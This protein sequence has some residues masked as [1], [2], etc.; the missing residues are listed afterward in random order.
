MNRGDKPLTTNHQRIGSMEYT[1]SELNAMLGYLIR[2][3][4][5]LEGLH[6]RAVRLHA[7]IES[8]RNA[9]AEAMDRIDS[10]IIDIED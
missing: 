3:A 8:A 7:N 10:I 5:Q 9:I 2:K 6:D 4:Q 1:P